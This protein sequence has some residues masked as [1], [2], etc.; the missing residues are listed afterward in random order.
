VT[1][2]VVVDTSGSVGQSEVNA[3]LAKVKGVIRAAGIGAKCLVVVAC[4][5]AVGAT[6]RVRRVE[7]VQLVGGGGG[8]MRVG[9][10]A[11]EASRPQP[12]VIVVFQRRLH[13]MARSASA[14]SACGGHAMARSASAGSAC[15]G[16]HRRGR[17]CR[18]RAGLGK[19]RAGHRLRG[20]IFTSVVAFRA[21]AV[22][23]EDQTEGESLPEICTRLCVDERLDAYPGFGR[24]V[25]RL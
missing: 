24:T 23:A 17:N 16:H 15:G 2:V 12:D 13:A 19:D 11:A 21:V 22:C 1:V 6:S 9:I 14:G 20:C 4:D 10:A 7:D 18:S 8:D 25:A 5:A 3:A